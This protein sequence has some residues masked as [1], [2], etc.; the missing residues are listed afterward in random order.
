MK[1]DELFNFLVG[2]NK[3]DE[4]LGNDNINDIMNIVTDI[5][6]NKIDNMKKIVYDYETIHIG[7][8]Q[9]NKYHITGNAKIKL[10]NNSKLK[11]RFQITFTLF[12]N[13]QYEVNDK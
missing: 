1:N 13:N 3:L 5:M 11:I 12:N 2:T 7:V 9:T 4:F 10:Y 8:K 6:N